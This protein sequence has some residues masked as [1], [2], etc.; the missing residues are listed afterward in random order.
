ME[1]ADA[2]PVMSTVQIA[3]LKSLIA[4]ASIGPQVLAVRIRRRC[5]RRAAW[6][7]AHV[8]WRL[9]HAPLLLLLHS[10]PAQRAVRVCRCC[11][12]GRR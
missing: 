5:S 8:A 11:S 12:P 4:E 10:L 3:Q 7:S 2:A 1:A 9:W 6:P